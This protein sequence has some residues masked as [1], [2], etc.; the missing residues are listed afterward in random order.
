M[1]NIIY[2]FFFFG[3]NRLIADK[4]YIFLII[5]I[6]NLLT[7]KVML[8]I[9]KIISS[10]FLVNFIAEEHFIDDLGKDH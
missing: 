9:N 7:T 10:V 8:L 2:I 1:G 6:K 4:A 3:V 5:D